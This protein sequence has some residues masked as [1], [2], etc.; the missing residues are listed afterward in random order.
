M[1]GAPGT[2][3]ALSL[4]E[5]NADLRKQIEA[6]TKL[7]WDSKHKLYFGEGDP[8]PYCL[9]PFKLQNSKTQETQKT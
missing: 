5:E 1:R 9:R 4:R 7:K 6:R 2:A 8:D 3:R